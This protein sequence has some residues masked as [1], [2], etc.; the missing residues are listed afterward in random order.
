MT[1]QTITQLSYDFDGGDFEAAQALYWYCVDYH[2]GQG[3][4]LYRIQ[5]QLHYTPARSERGVDDTE[6][7]F[8]AE[9]FLR[10][11]SGRLRAQDVLDWIVSQSE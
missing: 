3:S 11:V 10:L 4:E 2:E 1:E 6:S 5:S 9:V 7:T 8:A